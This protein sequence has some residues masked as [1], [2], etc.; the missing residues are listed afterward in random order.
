MGFF[1]ISQLEITGCTGATVRSFIRQVRTKYWNCCLGTRWVLLP[2]AHKK[3]Q[4]PRKVCCVTDVY[5]CRVYSEHVQWLIYFLIILKHKWVETMP[6]SVWRSAAEVCSV[7]SRSLFGQWILLTSNTI[8]L[9][10]VDLN[11]WMSTLRKGVPLETPW[12]LVRL[13]LSNC[14]FR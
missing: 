6:P 2:L 11:L 12:F 1:F 10:E 8:P 13:W 7:W 14:S 3:S 4:V 9:L 5:F